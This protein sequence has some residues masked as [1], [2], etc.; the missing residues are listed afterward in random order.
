M[1]RVKGA[2]DMRRERVRGASVGGA[3]GC[4][5][6]SPARHTREAPAAHPRHARDSPATHRWPTR[7]PSGTSE[8][9]LPQT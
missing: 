1:R 8:A 7:D 6:T 3:W 2:S 5:R 9:P 4:A